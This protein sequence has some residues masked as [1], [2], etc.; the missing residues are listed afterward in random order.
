M[1]LRSGQDV[2]VRG[3]SKRA[4]RLLSVFFSASGV[5]GPC[6]PRSTGLPPLRSVAGVPAIRFVWTAVWGI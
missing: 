6:R 5:K 3:L 2:V 4:Q 1:R